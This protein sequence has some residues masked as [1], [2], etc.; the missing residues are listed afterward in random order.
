MSLLWPG[1]PM[2]QPRDVDEKLVLDAE[3]AAFSFDKGAAPGH[4]QRGF[5]Y[6]TDEYSYDMRV[7][8]MSD[9]SKGTPGDAR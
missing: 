4:H 1:P 9:L 3:V 7:H 2:I 8:I 6:I 5:E